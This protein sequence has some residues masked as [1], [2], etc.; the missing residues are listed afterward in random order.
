LEDVSVS[1]DSARGDQSPGKGLYSLFPSTA[2]LNRPP[3]SAVGQITDSSGLS[4]SLEE[5]RMEL[6]LT[7]ATVTDSQGG[8]GWVFYLLF[9]LLFSSL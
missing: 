9:L 2:A 3:P 8:W 1:A 6:E 5:R 4:L 7:G